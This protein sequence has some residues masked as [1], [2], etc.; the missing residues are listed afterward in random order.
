MCCLNLCRILLSGTSHHTN[1]VDRSSGCPDS[2]DSSH[3]LTDSNSSVELDDDDLDYF[4]PE[5]DAGDETS[6][7]I[8]D[9]LFEF[10][11]TFL[12]G[13]FMF[14]LHFTDYAKEDRQSRQGP[15]VN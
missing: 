14:L 4:S 8:A 9:D 13:I 5:S 11:S 10:Y 15:S 3:S 7:S 1:P 6:T 2:N 12:F